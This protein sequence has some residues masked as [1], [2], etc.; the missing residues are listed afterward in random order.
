VSRDVALGVMKRALDIVGA[1]AIGVLTAPL[2]AAIAVAIRLVSP[3]PALFW[4]E[5]IGEGG[6]PFALVKFRT[7]VVGADAMT[8]E[9]MR[10]SRDPDWLLIDDDPRVFGLGRALRHTSL[11]ELPQLWNVLRGEMSLVGPRPL[12][13]RDDRR[14]PDWARGRSKAKP[15]LT[16][17]WQ[18][19]GRTAV[20]FEEM[21]ELD[22]LYVSSTW[23]LRRDLELL[24][25]TLPAVLLQKGSN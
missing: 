13:V 12:S 24:A 25:R 10:S 5:R 17:P 6:R 4:Q 19:A 2:M 14:V 20:P 16:G 3:G 22:C 11:D 9:L 1:T 18:V 21:V 15:G 7:M 23:S 8:A